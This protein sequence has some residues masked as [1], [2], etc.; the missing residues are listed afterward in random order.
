[1]S[2]EAQGYARGGDGLPALDMTE[3]DFQPPMIGAPAANEPRF[4]DRPPPPTDG[5]PQFTLRPVQVRNADGTTGYKNV[6]FVS[7]LSHGDAKSV[8][9]HKV[10]DEHRQKYAY[11][12]DRWRRGL[13]MAPTGTPLEMWPLVTPAQIMEMKLQNIF[14]V[15]QLAVVPDSVN[16]RIPMLAT[17]KNQARTWLKN[18]K[19]TDAIERHEHEMQAMRDGQ[20]TLQEQIQGLMRQN[21][22]LM[23]RM[24]GTAPAPGAALASTGGFAP[25]PAPAAPPVPAADLASALGT[26]EEEKRR[27]PG[28]PRKEVFE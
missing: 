11:H 28:R 19:E 5:L 14:T 15:E 25:P 27:G 18:K 3:P 16:H 1:M 22:E 20:A 13:Q 26:G 6:E 9:E 2:Q 12:Y 10:T 21:Q 17:L 24:L 4:Y 23:Q 8:P 7:I